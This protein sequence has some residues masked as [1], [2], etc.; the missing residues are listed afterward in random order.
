MLM[1]TVSELQRCVTND[2]RIFRHPYFDGMEDFDYETDNPKVGHIK[3]Q[4]YKIH[5]AG[6]FR[7]Y[8]FAGN[9]GGERPSDYARSVHYHNFILQ[10]E[11]VKAVA[12]G[13]DV[14]PKLT[15]GRPDPLYQPKL[16]QFLD[17]VLKNRGDFLLLHITDPYKAHAYM[18]AQNR[19]HIAITKSAAISQVVNPFLFDNEGNIYADNVDGH[20]L[21]ESIKLKR[22]IEGS[23]IV[24]IGAGGTASSVATEM[25]QRIKDGKLI[26]LNRTEKKAHDLAARLQAHYPL[27]EKQI[28]AGGL[29]DLSKYAADADILIS[30][31]SENVVTE[32]VACGISSE[33]LFVETN[34]GPA[35]RFSTLGKQTG[36]E[37]VDGSGMVY[38][39]VE[40][41][42][43]Q[44]FQLKLRKKLNGSTLQ[45]LKKEIG[46]V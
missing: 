7:S 26:I 28:H 13:F 10:A 29:D 24:L 23:K 12:F 35:A 41:A 36:H 32:P 1:T 3:E 14:E 5:D 11:G 44:A 19:E 39:G 45:A 40:R 6:F 8:L 27:T 21:A 9:V 15:D 18:F 25:A 46:M 34:Y 30:A 43:Q 33:T 17:T 16:E 37:A 2:L 38:F 4:R 22:N 20:A 31:I 42:A